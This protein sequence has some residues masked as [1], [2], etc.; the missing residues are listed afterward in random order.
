MTVEKLDAANDLHEQISDAR[1]TL[2]DL[3]EHQELVRKGSEDDDD[4]KFYELPPPGRRT[5][6][7]SRQRYLEF[8]EEEIK[9]QTETIIRLQN[10]FKAL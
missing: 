5:I 2:K 9:D 8:L 4:F 3:Q 10:E 6:C 1:I 7:V